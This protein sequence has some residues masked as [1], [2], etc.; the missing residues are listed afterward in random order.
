MSRRIG[1]V[2]RENPVSIVL[3]GIGGMG[4]VYLKALLEQAAGGALSLAGTVDPNPERCP[5]LEK[6]ADLKIPVFKTLEDFYAR[7]TADLAIISSPIQF[8]C[9][10]TCLA[11]ERGCFVLCEK[12][13]AATVQEVRRMIAERDK[14]GKWVAVGYQWSFSEAIRRLK[15]DILEGAFGRP[16]R[17]RCLYLWP[18]DEA[19]YHRNDWAGKKR[20]A[21]GAWILDSPANNAMAHDLHNMF[22]VLGRTTETSAL[23]V[24]VQAELY[25]ANPIENFDTIAL[26]CQTEAGVEIFFYASHAADRDTGP[27]FSYEFERGTASV[28]GRDAAIRGDFWNGESCVYGF[29]D[30]EPM[31]KLRDVITAAGAGGTPAC[32]LEAALGQTLCLNGAQDSMPEAAEFPGNILMARGEPGKKTISVEGL[33]EALTQCYET[34]LLPSE[35]DLPWS[36]KGEVIEI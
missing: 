5:D 4:A 33:A 35:M 20:D 25:R 21:R 34:C 14:A 10:Q 26:R 11:L 8:H 13:P 16:R 24:R 18:R 19:Y 17:L 9:E 2:S 31:K 27:V 30:A 32:G 28:S 7:Q 1:P 29:P 6:L 23:P 12:P 36:R 22:F 3:A 15:K